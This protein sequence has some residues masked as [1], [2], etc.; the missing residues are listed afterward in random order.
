MLGWLGQCSYR[1]VVRWCN[2][3]TPVGRWL[4]STC[5]RLR[6]RLIGMGDPVV[7]MSVGGRPLRMHLSH[8]LPLYWAAHPLYDRALPRIARTIAGASGQVS[9]ID[10]GANVGDTAAALLA[11]PRARV[12]SVEGDEKYF[13]LL[14][15]NTSRAGARAICVQVCCDEADHA[16]ARLP[17]RGGGTTRFAAARTGASSTST[18]TLDAI[19]RDAAPGFSPDLLKVDTDG[20]DFKVLRGAE[21]LIRTA[22]PAIF[23]EWQPEFLLMQQEDPF[24]IFP[25]LAERG[26]D[27]L[28]LYDNVGQAVA[29]HRTADEAALRAAL[30]RIDGKTIHYYDVLTV[31]RDTAGTLRELLCMERHAAA[32]GVETS[33]MDCH[34]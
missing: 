16:N 2:A 14:L 4:H 12:V 3:H 33:P 31:H 9:I 30:N 32:R 22:R 21:S 10:V 18:R 34:G 13:P 8:Q 1:G 26:Y 24:S 5:N 25:W 6:Y 28:L 11:D 23:F 29:I 7:T 20:F 17:V 19:V 27:E 15:Q